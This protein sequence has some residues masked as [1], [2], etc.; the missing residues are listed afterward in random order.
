M[1]LDDDLGSAPSAIALNQ[2]RVPLLTVIVETLGFVRKEAMEEI[3]KSQLVAAIG[4]EEVQWVVT[5]PAIWKDKAKV[6]FPWTCT[7]FGSAIG[8]EVV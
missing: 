5:V 6:L 2:Q 3:N 8:W 1:G 4:V 7:E